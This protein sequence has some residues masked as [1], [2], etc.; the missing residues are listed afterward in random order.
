[1][2]RKIMFIDEALAEVDI[3]TLYL[4]SLFF[5]LFRHNF[6]WLRLNFIFLSSLNISLNLLLLFLN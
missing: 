4:N 1:M 6:S 3:S 5:Y 2:L